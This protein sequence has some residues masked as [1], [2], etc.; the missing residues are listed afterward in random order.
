MTLSSNCSFFFF[1]IFF[2]TSLPK[3]LPLTSSTFT[4]GFL[5]LFFT[6]FLIFLADT[7]WSSSSLICFGCLITSSSFSSC[8]SS[9]ASSSSFPCNSLSPSSNCSSF[10]CTLSLV[11]SSSTGGLEG[12][13]L[14]LSLSFLVGFPVVF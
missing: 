8:C 2:S 10:S 13:N 14:G 6:L 3:P 4:A 1:R 7:T 9:T 5:L 11:S 12:R